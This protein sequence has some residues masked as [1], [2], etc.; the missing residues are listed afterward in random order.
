LAAIAAVYGDRCG[1]K[2]SA[3][4]PSRGDGHRSEQAHDVGERQLVEDDRPGVHGQDLRRLAARL[5]AEVLP[6][7][8][9]PGERDDPDLPRRDAAPLEEPVDAAARVAAVCW[10]FRHHRVP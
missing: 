9:I 3:C 8:G 1:S 6:I 5:R 10:T 4:L 7:G 2:R